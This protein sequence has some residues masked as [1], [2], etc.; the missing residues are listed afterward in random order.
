[1]K[2]CLMKLMGIARLRQAAPRPR[3]SPHDY[4][5]FFD[6]P[7]WLSIRC[8]VAQQMDDAFAVLCSPQKG[9]TELRI[10][11]A[12]LEALKWFLGLEDAL[13]ERVTN[14]NALLQKAYKQE[15]RLQQVMDL[16]A[17]DREEKDDD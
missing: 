2:N 12:Y 10:A 4:E 5:Q 9:E 13:R 14:N 3:I 6:S 11:Q 17:P 16:L 8:E 1:M 15:E 7:V